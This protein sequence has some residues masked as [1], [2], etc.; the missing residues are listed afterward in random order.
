LTNYL[1]GCIIQGVKQCKKIVVSKIKTVISITLLLIALG[2]CSKPTKNPD[3]VIKIE[4]TPT[5]GLPPLE[6]LLDASLSYHKS[7]IAPLQFVWEFPDGSTFEGP[8]VLKGFEEPGVY[9]VR[10]KVSNGISTTT[11]EVKVTVKPI[12]Q[13]SKREY[14]LTNEPSTIN[15]DGKLQI[16]TPSGPSG[17]VLKV[18]HLP[19]STQ[20]AC[21]PFTLIDVWKINLDVP[22]TLSDANE[23][24]VISFAVPAEVT[25]PIIVEW[26]GDFWGIAENEDGLPGGAFNPVT[27]TISIKRTH[28]STFA[29]A[30]F[31]DPI[32]K[33]L[34][35]VPD[36]P[37]KPIFDYTV[38]QLAHGEIGV[39]LTLLSPNLIGFSIHGFD[40][41]F[42]GM[43]YCIDFQKADDKITV[44]WDQPP[45]GVQLL[46][47]PAVPQRAK[48]IL[49]ATGGEFA[50]CLRPGC[51]DA[52]KRALVDWAARLGIPAETGL[53]LMAGIADKIWEVFEKKEKLKEGNF[54]EVTK[55]LIKFAAKLIYGL[56][57][58]TLQKVTVYTFVLNA[59]PVAGDIV[60]F[61]LGVLKSKMGVEP[62]PCWTV[63]I[64][65]IPTIVTETLPAG[66]VG[67][68]YEATLEVKGGDPPYSWSVI[69]GNLPPG[70]VLEKDLGKITGIPTA[71]GAW[72]FVLKVVD[73]NG[74]NAQKS[75]EINIGPS[76]VQPRPVEV[77]GEYVLFAK[78][79]EGET[80]L[81]LDKTG[82][83]TI[84]AK[85]DYMTVVLAQGTYKQ[86]SPEFLLFDLVPGIVQVKARILPNGNAIVG[87]LTMLVL[88]GEVWIRRGVP[89]P[90]PVDV[91]GTYKKLDATDKYISLT[92]SQ[93]WIILTITS[94]QQKC[95]YLCEY[96]PEERDLEIRG[97]AP[98]SETRECDILLTSSVSWLFVIDG[99]YI[100]TYS[101][102]DEN[103]TGIWEKIK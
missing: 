9:T 50:V 23:N 77:A 22:T 15:I 42:G 27:R 93:N 68:S 11:Q 101:F 38:E 31:L 35:K 39:N 72:K 47:R 69:T 18:A 55:D 78:S 46:L 29:L 10:L 52:F 54:S 96:V 84:T 67:K 25:D 8:I 1:F 41:G 5:E 19:I 81:R 103:W 64:P 60:A 63:K 102:L 28:F 30:K 24:F 49:P 76:A 45:V 75:F 2:S 48:V 43:W 36:V 82:K 57:A 51:E 12:P 97:F 4:A 90:R 7:G 66:N 87:T 86:V 65:P 95:A 80:I 99:K 56:A 53:G 14:Q 21:S 32:L 89:T 100:Y 85:S 33:A 6:V 59:V 40:L 16:I 74:L 91:V 70:L 58:K 34:E 17:R 71:E 62:D 83:F 13:E 44:T 3:I 73:K 98:G 92:L 20:P 79:K 94:G 37:P 61:V 88:T 26:L